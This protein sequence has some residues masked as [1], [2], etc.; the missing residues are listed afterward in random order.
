[1]SREHLYQVF[2]T[3]EQVRYCRENI[4][5]MVLRGNG[6]FTGNEHNWVLGMIGETIICDL[7]DQPRPLQERARDAGADVIINGLKVDVKVNQRNNTP[8]VTKDHALVSALQE[9]NTVDA[10][11]F[12]SYNRP[13]GRYTIVGWII[14]QDFLAK[15]TRIPKGNPLPSDGESIRPARCDTLCLCYKE[16]H[17]ITSIDDIRAIGAEEGRN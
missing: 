15:A 12:M 2:A 14:K 10:Y 9:H 1:M 13:T 5:N 3:E 16:L 8:R 4:G 6:E 7:L 17:R 11:L